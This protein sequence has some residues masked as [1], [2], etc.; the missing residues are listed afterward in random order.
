MEHARRLEAPRQSTDKVVVEP[1]VA[2]L[3]LEQTDP[4]L[5]DFRTHFQVLIQTTTQFWLTHACFF[6][7]LL[8]RIEKQRADFAQDTN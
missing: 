7:C 1:P 2:H 4:G 8:R 5:L 6:R 3:L